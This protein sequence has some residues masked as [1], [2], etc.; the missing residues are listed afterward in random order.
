MSAQIY[1]N[2]D[3]E[4]KSKMKKQLQRLRR[5]G[6]STVIIAAL[7]LC[8]SSKLF[9]QRT[10][11]VEPKFQET[12]LPPAIIL[13]APPQPGP[14]DVT[15]RP[16]TADEAAQIALH[17][18]PNVMSAK[19]G[20]TSA[21]GS[22]MQ[23][24]SGLYPLISVTG[25]YSH[26]N[27][28][29]SE[30]SSTTPGGS[31][32]SALTG[33][34]GA[35]YGSDLTASASI[36]QLLFDF[37]HTRDIVS[38]TVQNERAANSSLTKVENDLV[39]QVKQAFYTYIQ[40]ER[41]VTVNESNLRNQQQHLDEAKA[42]L[43]A[44]VGLPSDVVRAETSVADAVL[45]LNIAQNNASTSQVNLALLM[46][47]DPRTPINTANSDE[48]PVPS[49]DFNKM[50]QTALQD[51]PEMQIAYANLKA[52][53]F[54]L[55]AAKTTSAPSVGASVSFDTHSNDFP[56]GN[57]TWTAGVSVQWNPFDSGY[58]A[59]KVTQARG[60]LDNAVSQLDA[61]KLS[62]ISDVSQAFLNLRTAEQ[63]VVTAESE[64]A[65]AQ[66]A[67]DLANGRYRTGVGIFIDLTDAQAA[68][69]TAQTNQVNAL[70]AVS[71]A[72]V[73]LAHAL[74]IPFTGEMK[75]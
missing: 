20:V 31:G 22:T 65:N 75:K 59:G 34:N 46:G 28:I 15:N 10:P 30:I 62:V 7:C 66:V 5:M 41:L 49:N 72:R 25:G 47:I 4:I 63:R 9:A 19:A 74:G 60:N 18:Q 23:A 52:A 61:A 54:G 68:L 11:P 29:A 53:H 36:R 42:Q 45:N 32:G 50:V 3:H 40:N 64:V 69:L 38:E 71:Q 37:N 6:I 2:D 43:N 57:D 48:P 1:Q 24:R 33:S 56:P 51:R 14:A 67:V 27:T 17:H 58:T 21:K 26:T 55:D 39:L 16:L 13:P 8:I 35:S 44:G 12:P 73:A 70:S